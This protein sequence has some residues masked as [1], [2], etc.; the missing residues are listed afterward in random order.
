[1][2]D[3]LH[4]HES[5]EKLA[6]Q[7]A[8]WDEKLARGEVPDV[9]ASCES[10]EVALRLKRSFHLMQR[11]E[12]LRSRTT[13][14]PESSAEKEKS[15][16]SGSDHSASWR[17]GRLSGDRPHRLGRFRIV[18]ELGRGGYGVVFLAEDT[19]LQREVALK[20]PRG[21]LFSE[22]RLRDRF[23]AEARIAAAL[24]HPHIVSLYDAGEVGPIGYIAYAYCPGPSLAQWLQQTREPLGYREAAQLISTLA[25]ATEH[26]HQQ[27]ILHRDLKPANVIMQA[28]SMFSSDRSSAGEGK[29]SD[30]PSEKLRHDSSSVSPRGKTSASDSVGSWGFGT[31]RDLIPKITDFGLA[32]VLGKDEDATRTGAIVGTP[33]Y[34]SPEQASSRGDDLGPATDVYGLGAILYEVITGRP[35]FRGDSPL[36]T[37]QQVISLE[38]VSLQRLRRKVPTDLETICLKCLQKE[39]HRRYASAAALA[40]DLDRFLRDEPIQARPVGWI[41]R[42]WRWC[43]RH[44][45]VSGLALS[46]A[47]LAVGSVITISLSW[48]RLRTALGHLAVSQKAE[49]LERE[50]V[51]AQS[52]FQTVALADSQ[53]R[54]NQVST[55]LRLLEEADVSRRGWEWHYVHRVSQGNRRELKGHGQEATD[56]EFSPDGH[57][58]ASSAGRWDGKEPGEL[59]LWD[60]SSE[61]LRWKAALP[62]GPAWKVSFSPDGRR[63]LVCCF[64]WKPNPAETITIWDVETGRKILGLAADNCFAAAFCPDGK[65]LVSFAPAG[66]LLVWDC[67][68]GA[69]LLRRSAH[70][71][72]VFS[73]AFNATG[74][75]MVSGSRDGTVC[76]WDTPSLADEPRLFYAGNDVRAVDLSPDGRRVVAG[77]YDGSV[78]VWNAET[79]KR[80][81]PYAGHRSSVIATEFSPDGHWLASTG[82]DREIRIW[83]AWTGREVGIIRGHSDAVRGLDFRP[84]GFR[85]ASVGDDRT[86]VLQDTEGASDIAWRGLSVF[87]QLDGTID[88][89]T[90]ARVILGVVTSLAPGRFTVWEISGATTIRRDV[91]AHEEAVLDGVVSE[92]G[93][94]IVTVGG[95]NHCRIW[96]R[97]PGS[98]ELNLVAQTMVPSP[99]CVQMDF[100]ADQVV[101]GNANGSVH[102]IDRASGQVMKQLA[103]GDTA[104]RCVAF[105]EDGSLVA[106]GMDDGGVRLCETKSG[107]VLRVWERHGQAVT[108]LAIDRQTGLCARGLADGSILL[109]HWNRD[110]QATDAVH[111]VAT[112]TT[113][114]IQGH[115]RPVRSLV[116][117]PDHRRLLSSSDDAS[118]RLWDVASGAEAIVL[119]GHVSPVRRARFDRTGEAIMSFSREVLL[120]SARANGYSELS[121]EQAVRRHLSI[122]NECERQRDWPAALWHLDWLVKQTPDDASLLMRRANACAEMS[123]FAQAQ[124]DF[125]RA[126][127]QDTASLNARAGLC[128]L[129]LQMGNLLEF[130]CHLQQMIE[131]AATQNNVWLWNRVAWHAALVS[132]KQVEFPQLVPDMNQ[133]PWISLAPSDKP[134]L[135]NTLAAVHLRA[136]NWRE[137][138]RWS[139]EAISW[140]KPGLHYL[141][142]VIL[143][144]AHGA[145]GER[146]EAQRRWEQAKSSWQ[147][148]TQDP[149]V[150]PPWQTRVAMERWFEEAARQLG[151]L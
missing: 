116:F 57:W 106:A 45:L 75:R 17:A 74:Q 93:Q 66:D 34:M 132:S 87:Q 103:V 148:A 99:T 85:V 91:H 83:N 147:W 105:S 118:V 110:A 88:L 94:W 19:Q 113:R 151:D 134:R 33:S 144:L 49:R 92:D 27:G 145:L 125:T 21:D 149:M 109:A 10:R 31:L 71:Q 42:S 2:A 11:L 25:R 44:P 138:I 130:E 133:S 3:E 6:E 141:D 61:T 60:A 38:P 41:E 50:S 54:D 84:D 101:V 8:E 121:D 120:W 119:A 112:I 40:A 82:R 129:A 102:W 124:Q 81:L 77:C 80:I 150:A 13:G 89:S 23:L 136:N 7:I 29:S 146:E 107:Q 67:H 117:S 15:T 39:P 55:A 95:D 24:H 26:A 98:E 127:K 115:L 140:R 79:G 46:L 12:K 126:L 114:S 32:K 36:E 62:A 137:A 1:M 53:R 22:P 143:A 78:H 111:G 18:R 97:R 5:D 14:S 76:V 48:L 96:K 72:N 58:L 4:E 108:A 65:R 9:D 90:G 59:I 37:L 30:T 64:A 47:A 70:R 63:V 135:Y 128:C 51:A 28:R 73:L 69:L 35:P 100:A 86:V 123:Q 20:V 16:G 43:R 52:Y 56:V 104:V 122:L 139:R 142:E 68:T 131:A